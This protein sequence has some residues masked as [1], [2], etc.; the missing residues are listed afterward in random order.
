MPTERI[1]RNLDQEEAVVYEWPGAVQIAGF[2]IAVECAQ[3]DMPKHAT[4]SHL[5][6]IVVGGPESTPKLDCILRR[7]PRYR[8]SLVADM[9]RCRIH[10]SDTVS[11]C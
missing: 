9:R 1:C 2:E 4:E 8:T 5:R 10:G 6:F 7:C 11:T 3:V